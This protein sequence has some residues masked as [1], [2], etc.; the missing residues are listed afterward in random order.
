MPIR[1]KDGTEYRLKSPNPLVKQQERW[2]DNIVLHN[3]KW[4]SVMLPDES[5]LIPLVSDLKPKQEKIEETLPVQKEIKPEIIPPKQEVKPEEKS[6]IN[7]KNII[8][9]HCLPAAE[10][11]I[12][13]ELYGDIKTKIQYGDKFIIEGLVVEQNDLTFKFWTIIDLGKKSILYPYKWKN[14]PSVGDFRWWQVTST[15]IKANGFLINC[16]ISTYQPHFEI[17]S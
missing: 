2:G 12:K 15:E 13:D 4:E 6:S 9:M 5:D 17:I 11:V 10:K 8:L 14:G 7:T 3:L 16:I 1:N